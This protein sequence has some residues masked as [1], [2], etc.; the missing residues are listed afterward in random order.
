MRGRTRLLVWWIAAALG[1][2][3]LL[4]GAGRAAA[5][6]TAPEDV[7]RGFLEA[8]S[9]DDT[10]TML[11]LIDP[12]GLYVSDPGTPDEFQQP[13]GEFAEGT[14]GQ[15]FKV[16][17]HSISA[18]GEDSVAV[19]FS[20]SG[21]DIP[22]LPHPFTFTANVTVADGKITR[23]EET[24]TAQTLADLAAL[25]QPGMPTTGRSLGDWLPLTSLLGLT[26][27]AAGAVIRR[28]SLARR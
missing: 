27:I 6:T 24:L 28:R 5:Q 3:G 23:W 10:A 21:G 20:V 8:I 16:V 11:A 1:L 13:L 12:D 14:V 9:N 19:E 4:A 17:I 18:T 25:G 22:T 2:L 15:G 7:V 26:A